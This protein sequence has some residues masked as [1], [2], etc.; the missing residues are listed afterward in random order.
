MG[1][2]RWTQPSSHAFTL[3]RGCIT[4]S[5]YKGVVGYSASC[6][7]SMSA[8]LVAMVGWCELHE[9]SSPARDRF[10]DAIGKPVLAA[11]AT[12][13]ILNADDPDRGLHVGFVEATD[14]ATVTLQGGVVIHRDKIF[15]ATLKRI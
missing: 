5:G 11:I 10:A 9:V 4:R 1:A 8:S 6:C 2:G 15:R 13:A 3:R 7:S 14:Q 12:E